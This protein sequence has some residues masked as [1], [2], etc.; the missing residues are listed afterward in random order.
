MVWF[1]YH[2]GLVYVNLT[3]CVPIHVYKR[4]LVNRRIGFPDDSDSGI[5]P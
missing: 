1:D 4:K 3:R 2:R 5:S